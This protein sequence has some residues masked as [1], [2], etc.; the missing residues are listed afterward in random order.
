[1]EDGLCVLKQVIAELGHYFVACRFLLSQ[2]QF[3]RIEPSAQIEFGQRSRF[4]VKIE[5]AR[6]GLD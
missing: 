3:E 1:V 6:L 4:L 5:L 2:L